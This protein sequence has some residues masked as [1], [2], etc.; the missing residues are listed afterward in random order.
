MRA[1]FL[2]LRRWFLWWAGLWWLLCSRHKS[3]T[4]TPPHHQHKTPTPINQPPLQ[5]MCSRHYSVGADGVIFAL[6]G[7]DGADYTMRIYNSDGPSSERHALSLSCLAPLL[8]FLVG[9]RRVRLFPH[10]LFQ[11]IPSHH[12]TPFH[13]FPPFMP[14]AGSEPEMC[15]NGIRCLAKFLRQLEG[16]CSL[17]Y[18]GGGGCHVHRY[19]YVWSRIYMSLCALMMLPHHIYPKPTPHPQSPKHQCTPGDDKSGESRSYRISTLAGVIV[20]VVRGDGLVTVDMGTPIL[21]GTCER[22]S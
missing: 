11:F 21:E 20:P 1:F 10:P 19:L 8:W 13:P 12:P 22:V 16:P 15:G 14:A 6:P 18:L 17:S 3:V 7:K 9:S 5:Q 2:V 4:F